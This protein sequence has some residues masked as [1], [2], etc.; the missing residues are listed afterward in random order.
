M[1][2]GSLTYAL[3]RNFIQSSAGLAYLGQLVG[4]DLGAPRMLPRIMRPGDAIARHNDC[5]PTRGLC[6][7]FYLCE[8]WHPSFGGRFRQYHTDHPPQGLDPLPNRFVLFR[9]HGQ[10]QHDVEPLTE[11]AA[12]W[13][14]WSIT[15]WFSGVPAP[16]GQIDV[17][18]PGE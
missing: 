18:A 11:A 4:M 16:I 6:A 12:G 1:N 13:Q 15:L 14:R 17:D 3:F 2:P 9:P 7:L 5:L 10:A 8:G